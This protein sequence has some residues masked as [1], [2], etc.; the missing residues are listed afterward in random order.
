MRDFHAGDHRCLERCY[1]DHLQTVDGAVAAVVTGADR[2]TLVHEVF[3]RLLTEPSLRTSFRGGSFA[4]WLRVVARHQAID[5]ARR[6]RLEVSFTS[7]AGPSTLVSTPGFEQQIDVR[8]TLERF[9]ARILPPKWRAVFDARIV[10]QQDQPTAAR[11]LGMRRTTLAYQE[12]RIR[13]LLR[14]FVL[15]GESR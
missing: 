13:R 8:L 12:Y 14:R 4:S 2:E 6:R 1:R 11:A 15:R 10:A 3:F 9:R 7:E 5:Y